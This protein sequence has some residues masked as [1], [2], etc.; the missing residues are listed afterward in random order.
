MALTEPVIVLRLCLSFLA[1]GII[2]FERSRHHQVAGL[3]THILICIG[4]A[5]LMILSIWMSERFLPAGDPGRIA[6]QV[7]S[8]IG[9]LG[10]GAIIRLGNNVKGLT[11]A[12][13]LWLVAAIG[14]SLGAGMY[15]AAGA[16]E[17][18]SLITLYVL[19]IF[20]R[21]FLPMERNKLLEISYKTG[22]PL[23]RE[24]LETIGSF[25]VRIIT[26]DVDH[27][28]KGKGSKLRLLVGI[29]A[30]TDI[31]GMVKS[32]KNLSG[33]ERIDMKEKY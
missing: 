17:A 6:A 23:T 25:A 4:S 8:G 26:L 3:R 32:L 29:P 14:L 16:T 19:D 10:A 22:M 20:E 30:N 12:A 5:L 7:V 11:T 21:R 31:A 2:G 15:L 27:A 24:A 1:G 13:S 9:F 28:R 33:V 18:L